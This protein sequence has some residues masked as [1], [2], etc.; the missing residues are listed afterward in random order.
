MRIPYWL[1]MPNRVRRESD[2]FIIVLVVSDGCRRRLRWRRKGRRRWRGGR[3]ERRSIHIQLEVVLIECIAAIPDMN[4]LIVLRI[5]GELKLWLHDFTEN[6]SG[7]EE[8]VTG[9]HS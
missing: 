4:R 7:P 9:V 1:M 5:R 2:G 6:V 8:N 3:R